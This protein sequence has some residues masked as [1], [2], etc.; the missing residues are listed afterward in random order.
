VH[1][2]TDRPVAADVSSAEPDEL[3]ADDSTIIVRENET[4]YMPED[5]F[6]DSGNAARPLRKPRRRKR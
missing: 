6:A 2:R 5:L 1:R 3:T 4:G